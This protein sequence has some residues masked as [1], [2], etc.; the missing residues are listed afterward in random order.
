[1]KGK[2]FLK[3]TDITADEAKDIIARGMILKHM[4]E[5]GEGPRPLAGKIGALIFHKP[6]LR[7][8]VSFHV[9][10]GQLGG[11]SVY[12]TDAEIGFGKRESI[13]DIAR[14]LSRYVDF[15][16]IRTFSQEDVE[17][18]ARYSSVPVI[19][20]LTDL[21]HPCQIMGDALTIMEKFGYIEGVPI[22]YLGDPNNI[23]NS[24]LNL[25]SLLPMNLRIATAEGLAPNEEILKQAVDAKRSKISILHDPNEAVKGARV[26]YTDV[27]ASMHEKQKSQEKGELLA[28]FQVNDALLSLASPDVIVMHCL[29]AER[30]REI[31]DEVMDGPHSV[32]LDQ[33]ENRL[34]IQKAIIMHFMK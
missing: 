18:L 22:T 16:V 8:R 29:P 30:G 6:S 14:V 12:L 1:M 25:A 26:I 7:T 23:V 17:K 11:D 28:S 15:I 10:I 31:T 4:T 20:A 5:W 33:A 34:H 3:I 13:E 9:G 32:V 2:D 19:N 21:T 24:W 27:W